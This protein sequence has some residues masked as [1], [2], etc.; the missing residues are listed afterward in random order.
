[1]TAQSG[2]V[3]YT[4]VD[5]SV[6]YST[7]RNINYEDIRGFEIRINKNVGRWVTG[8]ANYNYRVEQSGDVGR[9]HYFEDERQQR[10]QGLQDPDLEPSL[11]RPI[12]RGNIIFHTPLDFG[13]TVGNNFKPLGGWNLSFLYTHE[14]GNY[15]TWDPLNTFELQDNLQW[16]A[17]RRLDMRVSYNMRFSGLNFRLY[18]DVQNLLNIKNL[19]EAS[20]ASGADREDYL[21]SLHLSLYDEQQYQDQGWEPGD[22]KPGEISSSDKDYIDMPN[23]DHLW[24]TDSRFATFGIN[25]SF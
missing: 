3:G 9:A 11:A 2:S 20:F 10:I 7:F 21:K 6:D 17:Y 18:A 12:F 24:Y 19:R 25:L 22:D 15:F 23:L 4:N 1:M 5:A 14:S 16:K 13:P 8:W